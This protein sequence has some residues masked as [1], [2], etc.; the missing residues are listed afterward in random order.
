MRVLQ[1]ASTLLTFLIGN[2]ALLGAASGADTECPDGKAPIAVIDSV[3]KHVEIRHEGETSFRPAKAG[4]RVCAGDH[5]H[6]GTR[7]RARIIYLEAD[8]ESGCG[9]EYYTILNC[10]EDTEVEIIDYA[11]E[12]QK[13]SGVAELL[14]GAIRT[15]FKG[16]QGGQ[17]QFFV[18]AGTSICGIRGSEG[19]STFAPDKQ[20]AEHL[21]DYGLM[22]CQAPTGDL[23]VKG[24]HQVTIV[25][26]EFGP[27][28]PL[29]RARYSALQTTT[30]IPPG[31][32]CV[33]SAQTS[34]PIPTATYRLAW[35]PLSAVEA[36]GVWLRCVTEDVLQAK[37]KEHL[38]YWP[39][40]HV[41]EARTKPCPNVKCTEGFKN[42]TSSG[43]EQLCV[44][45][46]IGRYVPKDDCCF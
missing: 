14:K 7:G 25:D 30:R 45:C 39:D 26:G 22:V 46:P 40:T 1:V 24:G 44:K 3:F 18:R 29:D 37:I 28:Q 23:N 20:T 5:I 11:A 16:F 27:V 6:T 10:A 13:S 36:S 33:T 43:G 31:T 38:Q 4:L 35:T 9:P 8:Y 32:R 19:I 12:R 34:S 17:S 42:A 41:D 15:F 2:V 21:M